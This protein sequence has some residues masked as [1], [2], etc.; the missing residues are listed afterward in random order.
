M[1]YFAPSYSR[2][3]V[4]KKQKN[5]PT[6]PPAQPYR[7]WL[8]LV[9]FTGA[10]FFLPAC[11]DRYLAPRFFFLSV[12]LLGAVWTLRNLWK[13]STDWRWT[14]FDLLLLAWYGM[15]LASIGWAFSWSEAVFYSQKVLL[16]LAVYGLARQ[17]FLH[18]EVATRQTLALVTQALT[19]VISV[20]LLI[21]LGLALS[22]QG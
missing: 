7:L 3:T 18:N 5:K 16:L 15:N 2:M 4:Q 9:F 1:H 17:A 6:A 21:Q 8:W 13:T 19:L 22:E 12:V 10:L 11:L 14:G 20:L